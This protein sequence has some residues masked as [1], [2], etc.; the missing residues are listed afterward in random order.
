MKS[1]RESLNEQLKDPEFKKEW[2]ALA[3]E[4]EIE[5]QRLLEE[6]EQEKRAAKTQINVAG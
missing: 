1:Y 5:L 4:Y 6:I 2:D 3:E